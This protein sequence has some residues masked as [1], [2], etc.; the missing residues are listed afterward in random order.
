MRQESGYAV[1]KSPASLTFASV[2][3]AS[4]VLA[5]II[6]MLF[7]SSLNF[8]YTPWQAFGSLL[9]IAGLFWAIRN[10]KCMTEKSLWLLFAVIAFIVQTLFLLLTQMHVLILDN[11][12]QWNI[13]REELQSEWYVPLIFLTASLMHIA[14]YIFSEKRFPSS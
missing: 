1:K 14:L 10:Q 5:C 6:A 4:L 9:I 7:G 2:N 3:A 12:H 11:C 13:G 8:S